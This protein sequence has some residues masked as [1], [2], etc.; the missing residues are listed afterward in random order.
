MQ[1][2]ELVIK[3]KLYGLKYKF[4]ILGQ[5]EVIQPG[6][7]QIPIDR[8]FDYGSVFAKQAADLT[9]EQRR[10]YDLIREEFVL[11]LVE[12]PNQ[13]TMYP[14]TQTGELVSEYRRRVYLR[15]L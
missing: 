13:Y 5:S 15:K 8:M 3:C 11:S 10:L 1:E 4:R 9:E 14:I 7:H 2:Q 6:D 12:N